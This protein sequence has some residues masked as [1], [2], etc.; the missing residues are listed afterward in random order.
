MRW[1]H[2]LVNEIRVRKGDSGDD[3][4]VYLLLNKINMLAECLPLEQQLESDLD[5]LIADIRTYEDTFLTLTTH[6]HA[7]LHPNDALLF[8]H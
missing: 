8:L 5:R 7:L 4:P 6:I 1:L 3:Y 2:N